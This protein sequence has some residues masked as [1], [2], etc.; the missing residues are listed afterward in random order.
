MSPVSRVIRFF[1]LPILLLSGNLANAGDIIMVRTSLDFPSAMSVLQ[2]SIISHQYKLTRVQRVDIGLRNMGYKTD[3]YRLVFFG[4][5]NEIKEL[6]DKYPHMIAY[7]P[8]KIAI[9]AE[10][11]DTLLVALNPEI[12]NT[13]SGAGE[14][15]VIFSRWENDI[16]S[17]LNEVSI[18]E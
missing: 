7:L 4:K 10:G 12:Y 6:V 3:K 15:R 5:Q 8:L 13:L 1:L 17:I 9:F 11:E 14:H 2:N 16:R 18:A